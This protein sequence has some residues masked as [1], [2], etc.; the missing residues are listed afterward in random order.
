MAYDQQLADAY[1]EVDDLR[2]EV[3]KQN[4]WAHDMLRERDHYK[5]ALERIAS[6]RPRPVLDPNDCEGRLRRIAALALAFRKG[7]Q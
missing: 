3:R 6:S 2:A 1:R 7:D 5:T 4:G